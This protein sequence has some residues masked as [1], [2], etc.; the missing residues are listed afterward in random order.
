MVA[1]WLARA[2]LA[3]G[4]AGFAA[5]A[6]IKSTV[7]LVV[8]WLIAASMHR[9]SAAARHR[10]WALALCG[11]IALPVVS[12][13][14]PGWAVPFLVA[15][16]EPAN[17]QTTAVEAHAS[18]IESSAPAVLVRRASAPV[19]APRE[20]RQT[21][22]PLLPASRGVLHEPPVM[23]VQPPD[24]V[25]AGARVREPSPQST[26]ARLTLIWCAGFV[27]VVAPTLLGL[28]ANNWLRRRAKPIT[29]H[30]WLPLLKSLRERMAVGR[31]VELRC[32]DALSIPLTWGV[33]HPVILVPP[34]AVSWPVQTRRVVLLHELAHIGRFDALVQLVGRFA[35]ALYW[36]HPL[37]W[38]ALHRLRTECEHACDDMVVLAGERSTDYARQ[39][40][41]LAKAA[42]P[43]KLPLAVAMAR[44]RGLEA[45]MRMLFD[46]T[47]SHSPLGRRLNRWLA[48]AAAMMVF[49]LAMIHPTQRSARANPS[50]S[51]EPTWAQAAIISAAD[52]QP[53]G[54]GRIRGRVVRDVQNT[55]AAGAD[56]MLLLPPPNGQNVYI[57]A[58]PLR[59]T[60]SDAYGAFAFEGLASG[61]HRIWANLGN[62]TSRKQQARGDVVVI[63]D[64]GEMP[65]PVELQLVKA[66]SLNTRVRDQATGKPIA[67]ATVHLGWSDFPVDA[68]TDGDGFVV[69]QPLTSERWL[70][71][72][73][74]EGC[75]KESRWLNLESGADVLAEF[76]LG[77]GGDLVGIVRDPSGIP[78]AGVGLSV[79][80]EDAHEQIEYVTTDKRGQFRLAHLPLK[81]GLAI[82]VA[83]LEYV[84]GNIATRLTSAK[85]SL[86]IEI[87]PRPEM[88]G[89]AGVILD[90]SGAAIAGAAL[91]NMGNST[92]E[93]RETTTGKDGRFMLKNLYE[94]H[95]RKEV[96]V[97]AK[98][99]APKRVQVET[100]PP[101]APADV[102]ISLD[103]GHKI[104]GR[105]I[106]DRNRPVSGVSVYFAH[107]NHA[108]SDGGS[109]TTDAEGRFTFD[110]LPPSSPFTFVKEGYSQIEDSRL[111]LD[112]DEVVTVTLT[113]AG[114]LVGKVIDAK[115]QKP[116]RAFNISI[117]FSPKRRPADSSG[118]LRS[119][120][121]SP[122]Q[123]FQS[124]DGVF[125]LGELLVDM[126]LQV[127]VSA[128]GYERGVIERAEVAR[129]ENAHSVEI[130]LEPLDPANLRTYRGRLVSDEGKPVVGASLRLI[131][132]R[133]RNRAT[134]G[135][136]PF[137]W[138]MIRTGQLAQVAFVTRFLE[139]T[140]D[141]D[142]RF[143][144]LGIPKDSDVELVWWGKGL[145]PGRAD[146]LEELNDEKALALEFSAPAP[147]RIV[148]TVDRRAYP[149]AAIVFASRVGPDAEF[150]NVS[151]TADQSK[152]EFNDLA[153]GEYQVT[154]MAQE[155][156]P[157]KPGVMMN[158]ELAKTKVVLGAA[159]IAIVEF[160]K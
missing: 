43:L 17:A 95:Q 46:D 114:V 36:F 79:S 3:D 60:K 10:L 28:L 61:R 30:G 12:W 40:L 56:V 50:S 9:S 120:L 122:G 151:L 25:T 124:K 123:T 32:S 130:A 100:G 63:P 59:A 111:L 116:I 18:Q 152:F 69:V 132:A 84:T 138:Q 70:V 94:S 71:E 158:R 64:S 76:A 98:G 106:D 41:N 23:S 5:N 115:T 89:I 78:V 6:V 142:G 13:L 66:V 97:T 1:R 150:L 8:A 153:P 16:A 45:R 137:N 68:K 47:R 82:R 134:P 24:V 34:D 118:S 144:F 156:V 19:V 117:T 4:V 143:Q 147:A 133:D 54:V 7:L 129:P 29:D 90:S 109:T 37:A 135:A 121:V 38:F 127:M 92:D 107:G 75:A 22:P 11:L 105:V 33:M 103:P 139:A 21:S 85:Q 35:A 160:P 26:T 31:T 51:K 119:D 88:G 73:W 113:P 86:D 74:A 65:K 157:D 83:K 27:F 140:T 145:A 44:S 55:P 81:V 57:G 2:F 14:L 67:G 155:H 52:R 72:A 99:F 128:D 77:P 48:A 108:F 53:N 93:V 159:E 58:L 154:M 102:S 141:A 136:F 49:G 62:L 104:E 146:R 101:G 112:G 91:R 131:A 80:R 126:P 42:R 15:E 39:L 149:D 125:K 110:S 96:L 20:L 87:Q 148:G